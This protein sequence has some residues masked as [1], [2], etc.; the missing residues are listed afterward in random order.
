MP[1]YFSAK[2]S[3]IYKP[4]YHSKHLPRTMDRFFTFKF[5]SV[6]QIREQNSILTFN[7]LSLYYYICYNT[8]KT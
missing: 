5:L 6:E 4:H 2:P 3:I 7:H 8:S 1:H